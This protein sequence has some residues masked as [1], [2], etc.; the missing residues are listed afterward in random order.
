MEFVDIKEQYRV[1]KSRIDP[2]IQKVLDHGQFIMG[3]EIREL[4]ERLET[5]IGAKHCISCSS[6]T[7]ALLLPLLAMG[8]GSGDEVITSPFTFIATA[9]MIALTGAMPVFVDIESDTY[10]LD[11]SKLEAAIT[12]RTRA[13]MPV[14]LYGH[15]A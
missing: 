2:R 14:S 7:D 9:E 5:F 13:V 10:N 11:P 12:P 6:G 4:E 8:V 15:P 1:L 3:P